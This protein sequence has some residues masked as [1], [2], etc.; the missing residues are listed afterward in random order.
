MIRP[1]IAIPAI[2]LLLAACGSGE[3]PDAQEGENV[4]PQGQVYGGT[5]SDAMLPV[6][7]VKSQSPQRGDN[8]DEKQGDAE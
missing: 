5:I 3:A 2:A 6:G 8:D 1:A 4:G 7:E